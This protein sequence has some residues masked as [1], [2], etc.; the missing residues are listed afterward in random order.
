M[1][2]RITIYDSEIIHDL[3]F[4]SLFVQKVRT[5]KGITAVGENSFSS[6][7]RIAY[8]I[9]RFINKYFSIVLGFCSAYAVY[10]SRFRASDDALPDSD[11]HT[12]VISITSLWPAGRML[13]RLSELIHDYIVS[14]VEYEFFCDAYSP[15]DP[16]SQQR[17]L[18]CDDLEQDIQVVL[19][20]RTSHGTIPFFPLG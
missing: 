12:F 18:T 14:G 8:R 10:D 7:E 11:K 1:N 5:A 20:S 19:S 15:S 3:D 2:Y 4:D 9:R 13:D 17:K 16:I 6:D